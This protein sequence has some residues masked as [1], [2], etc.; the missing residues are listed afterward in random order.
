MSPMQT[1]FSGPAGPR[2]LDEVREAPGAK[3]GD[4]LTAALYRVL[5]ADG[6][7]SAD[8]ADRALVA[9]MLLLA[10]LDTE[11]TPAR[12]TAAQ[13]VLGRLLVPSANAWSD[14]HE[15]AGTLAAA[16]QDVRSLAELLADADNG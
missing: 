1:V 15:R 8:A 4:L 9:V 5:S 12:I 6:E 2:F 3:A 11:L 13:G 10:D 16:Q 14:A 7:V